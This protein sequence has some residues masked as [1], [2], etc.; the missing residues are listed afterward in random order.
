[1]RKSILAL[2]LL[3]FIGCSDKPKERVNQESTEN[4]T[5]NKIEVIENKNAKEIKITTKESDKKQSKSY[6]YDYNTEK[7][8]KEQKESKSYTKIDAYS[9][10]RSPYEAIE[11]RLMA[12]K[13]SKEFILKCSP[14][15]DDYAN[16]I[17]GPS[18]LTR[19]ADFI[20]NR[21]MDYKN[22]T[23][24]NPL[25]ADLV[26]LMEDEKLKNIAQEIA[27]FNKKLRKLKEGR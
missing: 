8:K 2:V 17:I 9:R 23:K 5:P 1:M 10:I 16:G 20:Y 14:C 12:N 18:L 19:D 11:I 15:H 7:D 6:Y 21:I 27:L 3:F 22:G 26:K 13:L 4:T 24:L 25:M